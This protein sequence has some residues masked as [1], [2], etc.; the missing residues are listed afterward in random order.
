ME[1]YH[2]VDSC[3][4]P[5]NQHSWLKNGPGLSRCISYQ[6]WGCHSSESPLCDRENRRVM[7]FR[8]GFLDVGGGVQGG[9]NWGTLRIPREDWGTLTTL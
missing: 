5:V 7:E 3:Y 1:A 4:T 8:I 6:K 9:G 2:R